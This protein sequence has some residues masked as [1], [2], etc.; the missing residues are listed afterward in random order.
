MAEIF[1]RSCEWRIEAAAAL[2]LADDELIPVLSPG[3]AFPAVLESMVRAFPARPRI[4]VD[5]GAGP[6]GA[7]EWLR[8][9]TGARVIAVEPEDGARRV[10]TA[11]FPELI[12][13]DGC[14]TAT[15]L[16]DDSADC[17]TLCG[18]WSLLDDADDVLDEVARLCT[19]GGTVAIT[20]L[21]ADA[22]RIVSAPN[23]FRT[24]EETI[25]LFS[26]RG[27]IV[28]EVGCGSPEVAA[29]WAA[30]A[31]RVESWIE[32]HCAERAGYD[33]W[34]ADRDHLRAHIDRGDVLAAG[35][36]ATVS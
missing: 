13:V 23:V 33:E 10:A 12:V 9:A 2:G 11:T 31:A 14:A 20:D 36:V 17:V 27:W 7:S 34:V 21:F 1:D 25:S 6:G 26:E 15:G 16:E 24:L 5:I 29:R 8:R 4:V 3:A 22:T 35:L 32:L 19:P 18:V 28:R 30:T